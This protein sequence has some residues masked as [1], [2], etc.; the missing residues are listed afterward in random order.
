M[1]TIIHISDLHFG[2]TE[3]SLEKALKEIIEEHSPNLIIVSGDIT[4]RATASQFC[5][6]H[7][8]FASLSYPIFFVPGNHDIPLYSA[9]QRFFHPYT[10]Y[11]RY[12]SEELEPQYEDEKI[13]VVGVNTVRT[14]KAMEGRVNEKQIAR[15]KTIFAEASPHKIK[16][17]VS[18]HPFNVP[19]SH[20]RRP[21]ARA[22]HF[23]KSLKDIEIDLILSGHLHNTL[24]LYSDKTYKFSTP[25]PL[26]IQAGTAISTRHREEENS[27]NIIS[28]ST[29]HIDID[30]Y[31]YIQDKE[32]FAVKK[33]EH[34][35]RQSKTWIRDFDRTAP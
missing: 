9:W 19:M 26:I 8:F 16:I 28:L 18:H 21:L 15:V 24:G 31:E 22:R 32:V 1:H 10:L 7:T 13:L 33:K 5:L 14:F 12:I 29:G 20:R 23:W 27:F 25:G 17:L 6:A 4:Q 3:A 34:F 11:K 30:R 35:V 2:S